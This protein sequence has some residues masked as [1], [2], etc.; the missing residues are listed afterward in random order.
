MPCQTSHEGFWILPTWKAFPP[1]ASF[2]LSLYPWSLSPF[3]LHQ[4]TGP[5]KCSVSGHRLQAKNREL[6]LLEASFWNSLSG[7]FFPP[8]HCKIVFQRIQAGHLFCDSGTCLCSIFVFHGLQRVTEL[9]VVVTLL[10][11]V[12]CGAW[13]MRVGT[14]LKGHLFSSG[15][16]LFLVGGETKT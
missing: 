4:Q 6:S 15:Q 11:A 5:Q 3:P 2:A 14:D 16:L 10:R 12:E 8:L 7:L 13:N 1:V 9:A